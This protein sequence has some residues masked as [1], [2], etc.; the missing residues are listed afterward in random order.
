M[1]Q[2]SAIDLTP[3][4]STDEIAGVNHSQRTAPAEA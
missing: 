2:Q 3:A 1:R 4:R